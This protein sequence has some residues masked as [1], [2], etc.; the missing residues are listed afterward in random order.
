MSEVRA[1]KLRCIYVRACSDAK[2]VL[3]Q[4]LPLRYFDFAKTRWWWLNHF[5]APSIKSWFIKR[6]PIVHSFN[7]RGESY[8]ED[9]VR[10][11]NVL[12]PTKLCHVMTRQGSDKG[13]FRHNYTTIYSALLKERQSEPLRIFELGLGST[14]P[15]M[16]FNMGLSGRPGASLRGWREIF[17]RRRWIYGA[18]ISTEQS[19]FRKIASRRSICD[20]LDPASIRDLW[21]QPEFARAAYRI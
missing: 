7:S 18:E 19:Y 13:L 1:K 8:I 21:M 16:P 2:A 10:T 4:T 14:N 17:P 3:R 20:Q 11:V 6:T 9:R 15:D 5:T 12:A